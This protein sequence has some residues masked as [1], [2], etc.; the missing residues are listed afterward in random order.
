MKGKYMRASEKIIKTICFYLPQ[1]HTIPE[2]DEAYGKGFTEWTNVKK[3][4]PLFVGHN[5]P[6]IPLKE[7]YYCLL[8][9]GVMEKQA[10]LAKEYG[11]YGFCYYHYWFKDGKKVLEKPLEMMLKNSNINIPF[12]IC[13][14][15]E[16]W[17]KRWDGG[18]NEII[19]KQDYGDIYDLINHVDYL[20]EFFR[21]ERYIYVDGVPLLIIYKPELIP[22]LKNYIKC[23]RKRVVENGLKG[24]KIAVQYPKYFLDNG[25]LDL[26][27]YYIEFEPQFIESYQTN[28][29]Q[30]CIKKFIKS[31]LLNLNLVDLVRIIEEKN[32]LQYNKL[33]HVKKLNHQDYDKSWEAIINHEVRD[34]RQIAGAF[35]DWD[36][37]PRNKNGKVYD[38][39]TPEKFENY[40]IKLLKKIRREYNSDFLFV[41]AWNEWAEGAYFE[42]DEKN[43]FAYLQ[44]MKKALKETGNL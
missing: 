31:M 39:A 24:I 41:N 20:C 14:A 25:K 23:I 19:L 37:T 33:N 28:K 11:I 15:N 4:A 38:G 26:F 10:K 35:I 5:Q 13:W 16:N 7:N 27:D 43:G 8:D 22:Q 40:M 2:N 18:N 3:A 36:N 21:D 6:R 42:P 9:D 29:M 32:A 12:C 34:K 44:A 17:T 30:N 1:F